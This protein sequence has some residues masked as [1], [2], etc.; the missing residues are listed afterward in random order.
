MIGSPEHRELALQTAR[1]AV[2]L[3]K[4]DRRFLPLRKGKIR[5]LA[6]VG[7]NAGTCE[8]GDYSGI[9]ATTPVSVLEGIRAEAGNQIAVKYAPW[10]TAKDGMEIITREYY[11]DG[12]KAEYYTGIGLE[13]TPAVRKEEW[14]NHEPS[15]Q[16]PDPFVPDTPVSARWTG[17]LR[18]PVSGD[19]VLSLQSDAGSRLWLDGRLL[20]DAWHE[21][22][23]QTDTVQVRL[24]AGRD[25]QLKVEYYDIRDYS[26]ARLSWRMPAVGHQDRLSLYGKAG[27]L[28]RECDAVVAVMGINK[29]IEREGKDR[30]SITLPPDQQEFL[31][32]LYRINPNLVLVLVAGSSLSLLWEDANLPAIV[33][34][35]YPGQEGGSAVAEVLFGKYNPAGRLPLTYYPTLEDLPPFDDYD[36]T[37]RTY[38][39]YDGEVLYPFGYGLS[40]TSFRYSDLQVEDR[41]E[42]VEVSFTLKNVGRMD[43]DEVAQV[44][45]QLP[46]YEGVAPIKELRGFQRVHLRRGESRRVSVP[47]RREDLR[48]WSESKRAFVVPEGLPTVMVG[49]SSADIRLRQ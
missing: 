38:K 25:Y 15:N 7:I 18:P 43:G 27:Q 33:N 35:W 48:Y 49:A 44:Y 9:P 31:H 32:E 2:V 23:V 26:L 17:P 6:V 13:G 3:L 30:E 37:K 28:A 11:P 45:V 40:Y 22:A 12:L 36:I 4:N 19:Y 41:G 1:E 8:L 16:P 47:L 42:V 10:K 24:E 39:Y 20:I 14:L 21:H 29:S 46:E 34:A 5:S